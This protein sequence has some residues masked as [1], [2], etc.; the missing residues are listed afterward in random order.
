MKLITPIFARQFEFF[1]A[2][3]RPILSFEWGARKPE[4]KIF[5][6]ALEIAGCRPEEC[7][8]TDDIVAY[9]EAA[10]EL[11]MK[12][13]PFTTVAAFKEQIGLS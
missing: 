5:E 11:G 9:I 10:R 3:D 7:F 8:Y 1:A 6:A 4:R 2:F 13:E 12:A